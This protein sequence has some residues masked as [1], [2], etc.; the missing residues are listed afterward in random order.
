MDD[1][2]AVADAT[3]FAFESSFVHSSTARTATIAGVFGCFL[4]DRRYHEF[5]G[6]FGS[7]LAGPDR[8]LDLF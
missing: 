8:F 3:D 1:G 4:M 5:N 2:H 6:C 7:F